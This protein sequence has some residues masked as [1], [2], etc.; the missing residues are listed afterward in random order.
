MMLVAMMAGWLN[1][2]QQDAIASY[3]LLR[4]NARPPKVISD[5]VAGS[6]TESY[7]KKRT[8]FYLLL[9]KVLNRKSELSDHF[10]CYCKLS[11]CKACDSELADA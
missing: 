9:E 10:P 7:R 1:R 6:G 11:N 2:Q 4:S 5:I 8:P 3:F